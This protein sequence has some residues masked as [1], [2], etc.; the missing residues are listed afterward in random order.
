MYKK[1]VVVKMENG[2]HARPASLFIQKASKFNSDIQ[3]QIDD[4][5]LN[6]KSILA[7]ISAGIRYDS[8]ITI[9]ADG[10]DEEQAVEELVKFIENCEE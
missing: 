9:S 8:T 5:S 1:D 7:L 4:R 2:L 3:I 10:E 6:A